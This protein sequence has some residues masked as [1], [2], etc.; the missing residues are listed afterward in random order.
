MRQGITLIEVVLV[1]GI[2]VVLIA[3]ATVNL[4]ATRRKADIDQVRTQIVSLLSEARSRS[5]SQEENESWGV[6]FDNNATTSPFYALFYAT[7]AASA[8]RGHYRL[9]RNVVFVSSTVPDGGSREIM[10]E[11]LTG[12]A[13]GSRS[14]GILLRV[15]PFT[16]STILVS[17]SGAISF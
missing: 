5:I 14:I 8:E 7:Y 4:T 12:A 9:P 15:S 11:E 17:T 6:R 3:V 2:G 13:S 10:F 16:S 1:I